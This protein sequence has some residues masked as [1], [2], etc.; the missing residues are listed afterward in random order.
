M[1]KRLQSPVI[2]TILSEIVP[3]DSLENAWKSLIKQIV[4]LLCFSDPNLCVTKKIKTFIGPSGT[5]KTLLLAKLL[6]YFAN[7]PLNNNFSLIFVNHT[8]LKVLE[9]AKIYQRIFNVPTFYVETLDELERAYHKSYEQD[10]I[11]IDFPPF[12]FSNDEN[13]FYLKFMEKYSAEIDTTLVLSPHCNFS[14][15]Q[16][17]INAFKKVTID[18]LTITKLDECNALE[19]ILSYLISNQIPMRHLSF[20]NLSC[21]AGFSAKLIVPDIHYFTEYL[22]HSLLSKD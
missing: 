17:Y 2:N 14:Y 9:E 6:V 16:R 5:G 1:Q 15:M 7:K 21:R 19:E 11:F 4:S 10:H 12:D 20:G 13:N 3:N 18:G 22:T 8:N